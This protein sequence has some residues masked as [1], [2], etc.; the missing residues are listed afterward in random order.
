MQIEKYQRELLSALL[1]KYEGSSFFKTGAVPTRRIMIRLYDGGITD[2][3]AYEIEKPEIKEGINRAVLSLNRDEL[4]FYQWMKGEKNH[5]LAKVW[6]DFENINAAYAFINRRPAN[7]IADDVCLELLETLEKV[8]SQWI[9]DFLNQVY[10]KIS[11]KRSVGTRFAAT[12]L[13]ADSEERRNL[14]RALVFTDHMEETELLERVFSLQCFG[15]SKTFENSVRKRFLSIIRQYTDCDDNSTDE[16]LLRFAGIAKYPEQFEFRGP[17][18]ISF[19]RGQDG[20]DDPGALVNFAPLI[21]GGA[22]YTGDLK[23]GQLFLPPD[24]EILSIENRA[25]YIDYVHRQH[26]DKELVV[27]HGGNYSPARGL[28]L[29]ALA[30]GL[31]PGC[32][33]RHWGDIDYGGFSMLARLRREIKKDVLPYRMDRSELERYTRFAVPVILPY[34]EKLKLLT[35]REELT[36]SLPCIQYMIT[37]GVKLEQEAMLTEFSE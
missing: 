20:G 16:E 13:P 17:L 4:V 18:S 9:Q 36:D 29:K 7:D 22:L 23:R 30:A 24:T 35:K 6:L 14:L 12:G 8:K 15:D 26:N 1:D 25:N 32:S 2:F 5:F 33:W 27:Y 31:Q 10:E 3:P 34:I 37:K 21:S 19:E 11:R 28:F